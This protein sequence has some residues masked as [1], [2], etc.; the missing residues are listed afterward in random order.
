MAAKVC[1]IIPAFN[2]EGS[3]K[4][5]VKEVKDTKLASE[6]LIVNDGST[7]ET[8]KVAK[9]LGITLISLPFNLGIGG[10]VQTGLIYAAR[11]GFD[12]A[13]QIDA[14]GQ[15]NPK[16]LKSLLRALKMGT[17]M[18]IGS[19]YIK[20]TEYKTG[21][22]RYFGINIFSLLI[23]ATCSKKIYD[24]TSGYRVFGK[25]ALNFAAVN[26]PQEFPEP[27]SIVTFL[28]NGFKLKEV[29]VEARPRKTGKSSI[30][31]LYAAYLMFSISIAILFASFRK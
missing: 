20:R 2:E 15:H 26:Y 1:I 31:Y 24:T 22:L 19:R 6:I 9:R 18:V 10:A 30:S 27:L 14:D 13:V 3:I 11:R 28:K 7:D 25:K 23:W 16:Y 5:V 8:D 4:S 17:D 29:P 21:V 12:V